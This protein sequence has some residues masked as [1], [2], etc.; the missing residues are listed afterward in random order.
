MSPTL[1]MR[2]FKAIFFLMLV[3]FVV[4][5]GWFTSLY[6]MHPEGSVLHYLAW[7][8]DTQAAVPYK[9]VFETAFPGS[10]LFQMGIGHFFG[11]DDDAFRYVDVCWLLVLMLITWRI[12]R[13][14]NPVIAWATALG[15]GSLYFKNGAAMT[16]QRDY[17]GILPVA[18]ALLLVLQ[19]QWKNT[20]RAILLGVCF[21]FAA[22]MKPHLVIGAPAILWL[23][24]DKKYFFKIMV[25]SAVGFF[26][27]FGIPL[28]WL[29]YRGAMP[30]FIDMLFHYMPLYLDLDGFVNTHQGWQVQWQHYFVVFLSFTWDWVL[31]LVLA[32]WQGSISTQPQTEQNKLFIVLI[33]LV[34]S[35]LIY[36]FPANKFYNYH[37][38][39]FRYFAILLAGFLLLPVFGKSEVSI[40][41]RIFFG[42]AYLY[43]VWP[44]AYPPL[45]EMAQN[46]KICMTTHCE[47]QKSVGDALG[48]YLREHAKPGDRVQ[49]LDTGGEALRAMLHSQTVMATPYSTYHDLFH[50][51]DAPFIQGM[52]SKFLFDL[53]N[54][55]P[56]YIVD[57]YTT[58]ELPCADSGCGLVELN[59]LLNEHYEA[60]SE[61]CV[62]ARCHYRIFERKMP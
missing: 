45:G 25:F 41:K 52:R 1:W 34:I 42:L 17:V 4:Y 50:H 29:W 35:Y 40:I 31:L 58:P 13:R 19:H 60:V 21:G 24:S 61:S 10:F 44:L 55:M 43:L 9:D 56:R 23:L 59:Q 38:M 5:G 46:I 16:L 28:V 39:P 3:V 14:I 22:S 18:L 37:W 6:P 7:M 62:P 36:L 11:Y 8:I 12:M 20:T 26:I 49:P 47:K 30:A 2:H 15:F 53:T 51:V 32:I 27:G 48:N 57:T 33:A 54:N